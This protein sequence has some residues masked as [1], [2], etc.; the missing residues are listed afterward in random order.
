MILTSK[1]EKLLIKFLYWYFA[2]NAF[3]I[4]NIANPIELKYNFINF[5]FEKKKKKALSTKT[6]IKSITAKF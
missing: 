4:D 2:N 3:S 1:H 5:N 6:T